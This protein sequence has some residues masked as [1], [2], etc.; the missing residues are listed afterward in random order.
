MSSA[1][2]IGFLLVSVIFH[3]ITIRFY[4]RFSAER[5]EQLAPIMKGLRI[6]LIV[7]ALIIVS[8]ALR[9]SL[10]SP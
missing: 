1:S 3:F 9:Q 7:C 6:I 8:S 2:A 4:E 10:T 5:Q